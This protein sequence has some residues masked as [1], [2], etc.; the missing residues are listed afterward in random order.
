MDTLRCSVVLV[1]VLAIGLTVAAF[2][3]SAR[4]ASQVLPN[5][6]V[7]ADERTVLEIISTF[8]QAQ[9]AIRSRDLDTLMSLYSDRYRYYELRKD[10]V[11]HLW[12]DLFAHYDYISNMH[13]FGAI[14][15]VASGE[16]PRAEIVCTGALWAVSKDT[17]ER[18]RID[19]WHDEV[20]YLVKEEGTWRII[21]S[22]GA[23]LPRL[24]Q[25]GTAPHPLF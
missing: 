25:F 21:G 15:L 24:P 14:K 4:A 19:S 7:E 22:A 5:A 23:Q 8:D 18:I 12:A 13:T 20:H 11:R 1:A 16:T 10:G 2:R 17:N 6:K 9:E 3:P